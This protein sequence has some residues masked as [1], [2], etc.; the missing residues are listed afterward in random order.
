[1]TIR[2]SIKYG[3]V[4]LEYEVDGPLDRSDILELLKEVVDQGQHAALA[5]ALSTPIIRGIGAD[6]GDGLG[7]A[8]IAAKLSSKSGSDLIIASCLYLETTAGKNSYDRT[9][10]L[11][12]MKTATGF[13]RDT[14]RNNLSTYLVGLV[15]SGKI[16]Q[17]SSSKY[18]LHQKTKKELIAQIERP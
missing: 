4:E 16:T 8:S 14:Y 15:R 2:L 3:P 13:Y 11:D 9:E 12:A 6:V 1:M 10:I 7:V 5:H 17:H 18:C